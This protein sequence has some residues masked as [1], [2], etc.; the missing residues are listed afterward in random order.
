MHGFKFFYVQ[1]SQNKLTSVTKLGEGWMLKALRVLWSY[2]G[3]VAVES[4]AI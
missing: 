3:P 1:M 2:L 4:E